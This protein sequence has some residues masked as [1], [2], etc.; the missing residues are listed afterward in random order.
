MQQKKMADWQGWQGVK[1][2]FGRKYFH[3]LK[4]FMEPP[5]RQV[6]IAWKKVK[7]ANNASERSE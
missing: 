3:D 1:K 7:Q 5:R 6:A 4:D 2:F